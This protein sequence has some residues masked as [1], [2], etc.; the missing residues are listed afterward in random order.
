P[1][2]FPYRTIFRS[3]VRARASRPGA[4]AAARRAYLIASLRRGEVATVDGGCVG[5]VAA[6]GRRAEITWR[7]AER[8]VLV[9]GTS[10]AAVSGVGRDLA[11]AAI[12]H[13]KAVLVIDLASRTGDLTAASVAAACAAHPPPA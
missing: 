9:T 4:P 7:E 3:R 5:I 6:T 13:R 1:T 8:G 10:P 2:R 12:Q 11:M